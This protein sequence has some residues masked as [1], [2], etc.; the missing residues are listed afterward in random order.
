MFFR[1]AALAFDSSVYSYVNVSRSVYSLSANV[2]G[3][4][5]T[6]GFVNLTRISIFVF[7][8]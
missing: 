5:Y 8:L 3:K 1:M 4:K 2:A 6:A 7:Q